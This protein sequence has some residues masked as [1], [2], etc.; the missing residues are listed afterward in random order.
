MLENSL[1]GINLLNIKTGKYDYINP[2]Q[3]EITGFTLEDLENLNLK[4]RVARVHPL[5]LSENPQI[6]GMFTK[7]KSAEAEFSLEDKSGEYRWLSTRSKPVLNGNGEPIY[8]VTICRDIT[9]NKQAEIEMNRQN[10]I[11]K[12]I[13]NIY[14]KSFICSTY[15][16]LGIEC[17]KIIS[18]IIGNK[19][20]LIGI[21]GNDGLLY[22]ITF[23]LGSNSCCASR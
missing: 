10:N 4:E 17:L 2:A 5:D 21:I 23:N 11:L 18:S 22:N 14:E 1:D 6:S 12:A 8:T 3:A 16:E 13:N 20:G 9:K 7:G 15:Q 19:A